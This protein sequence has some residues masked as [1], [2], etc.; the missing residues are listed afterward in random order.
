GYRLEAGGSAVAYLPDHEP[1]LG[2]RGFP[3]DSRWTS[4]STL[5][6]GTDMLIHDSQYL[7]A[8][9]PDHIGWGHS[10][11]SHC[12]AFARLAR[13]RQLVTFHH[14]PW[15]SDAALDGMVAAARDAADGMTVVA[16]REGLTIE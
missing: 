14:D 15:H 3:R 10:G 11:L 13:V 1:A 2:V 16:G 6:D 9:Y 7:D 4:G 12:V 5:A 8:E